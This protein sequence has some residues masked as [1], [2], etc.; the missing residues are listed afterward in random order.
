E[1]WHI[2]V[3]LTDARDGSLLWKA[4]FD[5]DSSRLYAVEGPIA[6]GLAEALRVNLGANE[7][8]Q[9]AKHYT[10]NAEAHRLY[11]EGRH[12]WNKR[13]QEGCRKA[14]IRFQQATDIDPTYARAWTGLVDTYSFLGSAYF[15][16]VTPRVDMDKWQ[17]YASRP[18]S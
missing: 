18:L 15:Y 7:K 2:A 9:F 5:E 11:I 14:I 12:Y 4:E 10:E 16:L 6:Q 13:D 3:Q 17:A 8:Q 1:R